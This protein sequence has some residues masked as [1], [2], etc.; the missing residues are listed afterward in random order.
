MEHSLQKVQ[1]KIGAPPQA[2]FNLLV[3]PYGKAASNVSRVGQPFGVLGGVSIRGPGPTV[4]ALGADSVEFGT[5]VR[6]F[7]RK[8]CENSAFG[9]AKR[10]N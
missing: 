2:G 5:P 3:N 1:T 4:A 9:P 10:L 8:R 7:S 6:F